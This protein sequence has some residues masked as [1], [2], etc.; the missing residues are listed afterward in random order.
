MPKII[1]LVVLVFVIVAALAALKLIAR[2]GGK[3]NAY[4][5]RKMLF[6]AAEQAFLRVLE[7]ALP[8]DVRVFGKVRLGDVFGAKKELN[9][10]DRQGARNRIDRKHVDFLLVRTGDLAPLAGIELDDRSHEAEER[11]QRDAFVDQVFASAGLPLFHVRVQRAYDVD[12]LRA[13]IGATLAPATVRRTP[14]P[15]PPPL[16]ATAVPPRIVGFARPQAAGVDDTAREVAR[17]IQR[18]RE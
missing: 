6:T 5:L 11:Q 13:R 1:L 16:A 12:E 3:G 9:A 8:S 15:E 18:R 17:Q 14:P 7:T 2:A 10:S 4:Y